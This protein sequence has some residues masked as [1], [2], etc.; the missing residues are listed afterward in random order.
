VPNASQPVPAVRPPSV[1][2]R[3]VAFLFFGVFLAAG[4]AFFIG[5]VGLPLVRITSARSWRSESC[6]M[7]SSTVHSDRS[8]DGIVYRLDLTYRYVVDDRAY[9]GNRYQFSRG[10]SSGYRGKAA[11]V[12]RLTPGTRT[13]CW[14]N[15]ADPAD[16][17]IER[18]LTADLWLGLI[19][20]VFV[21]IG[22]GGLFFAA[23]GRGLGGLMSERPTT[24][25]AVFTKAGHGA[26]SA[27][28]RPRTGRVA[29]LAGLMVVTV[30]WNGVLSVFLYN[31]V[32]STWQGGSQWFLALFLV[33][34][35]LVGIL[36][37]VL[38][39][40]QALRLSN[41]WPTVTVNK[42]IVTLG[43]ELRVDWTL[44][45]R[46]ARL[47]CFRITLEGREEATYRRGTDTV[48]DTNI[49]ESIELANQINPGVARAGSARVK[50]PADTMHSFTAAH[51][52]IVWALRVRGD[53][54]HWPNSDDEFPLI[55]APRDR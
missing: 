38:T 55:V 39:I 47:T 46:V 30:F 19:P 11:I 10:L 15:P 40:G 1:T 5:F 26:G 20:L 33:P 35:V 6:Q 23:V 52:K 17:V 9:V 16:A 18:G 7:I 13:D 22:G 14:V 42:T 12:A 45:G 48:T 31:L 29:K 49:F 43:E 2:A 25:G 53:I 50:I 28:L 8:S 36:V 44:V 41:P 27:M 37:V 4:V 21:V 3:I 51:N 34:F 24:R 54:R 32:T